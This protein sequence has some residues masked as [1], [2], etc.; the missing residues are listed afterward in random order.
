VVVPK[1]VFVG[2]TT[3]AESEIAE[4]KERRSRPTAG[5]ATFK[6]LLINQR[7]EVACQCLLVALLERSPASEHE[8]G[9]RD[10]VAG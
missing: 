7:D 8:S 10:R 4:I 2:E 9:T 6:H 1:L 5:I 3:H